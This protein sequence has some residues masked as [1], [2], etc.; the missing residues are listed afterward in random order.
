MPRDAVIVSTA[1]TPIGRAYKGAFN[2]TPGPTL[3]SFSLKPAIE[4][5]GID[6]GDIDDVV[7][8]AVLTQGTQFGNIGRQ[9][10]LRA[11]CPVT[12]AAMTID[13]QCSSGLMA[14][15]TAAK[16]IIVDKMDV[17]A[18]GGQDSISMVQTPEMRIQPDPSLIA[19]HKHVYMPM[20]QTA[21]TVARRYGIS[22]DR[23]DE[24]AL[25]SQ[26]RTAAA[27]AAGRFDDEIVP[28]T[29]TM[30]VANKETGEV[31]QRE[32][33]IAKDEG[34]R[35]DT[36]LEGLSG[37][38]PVLGP[39]TSITAGNAS[40]LSDGSSASILMEATEA[41]RRGLTPMGRYVGMAVA[42]TEPDEMGIGPIDAVNK[43]LGRFDLKV[44]DIGLWELNE[45]FA[46]QVLYSAEQL[47][48]PEDRLNVDGGSISI[49]HPYGMSGAR[50][51]GHAL[52]E[53]KRRGVK[54]VV[55]TM[56]VGGGMGAA[57][58]FEVL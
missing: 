51:T 2:A 19:M 48:I 50:M 15:A 18:A 22:R 42:G 23:Q 39:E 43:L 8:G 34:N 41:Q 56:C 36:T 30:N 49:G 24:Y 40:Q 3:G 54:Y 12:V 31:S 16:Q 9:V 6:P 1:R 38:N 20:L 46:V 37:L 35:A 4:R 13:R 53:G 57:G 55:V 10:A 28:V 58:L 27:Q 11:G 5:A 14:I 26:Q 33:T 25:K 21:E 45:A 44:D 47:G 52:I 7:W 32:V 29:T 17:V